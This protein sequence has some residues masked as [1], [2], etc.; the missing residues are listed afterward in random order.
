MVDEFVAAQDLILA[1]IKQLGKVNKFQVFENSVPTGTE[2]EYQ[3]GSYLPYVIV[4]FGGMSEARQDWQGITSSAED[5]KWS[6][7][8]VFCVGDNPHTVRILKS[9]MRRKLEGLIPIY[10]WGQLTE[11]LSGDFGISKPDADLSPLRYGETIAFK[12]VVD[13]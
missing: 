6:S 12:S 4:G 3:N 10:G 8:V 9:I 5:V 2:L 13:M 1:E 7:V 11:V